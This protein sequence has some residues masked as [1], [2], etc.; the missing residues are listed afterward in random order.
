M[1]FIICRTFSYILIFSHMVSY[2]IIFYPTFSYKKSRRCPQ[3]QGQ[4]PPLTRKECI[5]QRPQNTTNW[6][7]KGS[8]LLF[9]CLG[10]E[11]VVEDV[12]VGVP[13]LPAE[14]VGVQAP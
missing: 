4:L 13:E 11:L 9:F 8:V 3:V 1:V 10:S 12:G 14:D 7:A 5:S 6:A 2:V